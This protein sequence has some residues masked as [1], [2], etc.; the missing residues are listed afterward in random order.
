MKLIDLAY[1]IASRNVAI[2]LWQETLA[3]AFKYRNQVL[4]INLG[5]I[6]GW[7]EVFESRLQIVGVDGRLLQQAATQ[8][9]ANQ[10][11]LDVRTREVPGAL[12]EE[13]LRVGWK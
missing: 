1:Q 12:Q 9:T 3:G 7:D 5:W 2:L 6:V 13:F 4:E 11:R 8:L 10:N